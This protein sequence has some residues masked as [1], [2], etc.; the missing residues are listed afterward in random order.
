MLG[1]KLNH[2]SKR[3]HWCGWEPT[4]LWH[5]FI[6]VLDSSSHMHARGLVWFGLV[7][8]RLLMKLCNWL[9][10]FVLGH[11]TGNGIVV[12]LPRPSFCSSGPAWCMIDGSTIQWGHNQHD[13]ISNHRRLHC[14]LN[15]WFRCTS[16]KTSKLC[17]TGHCEG[18]SSVTGEFPAQKANSAD[19]FHLMTS[20]WRI[21]QEK[22]WYHIQCTGPKKL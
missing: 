16:K 22:L 12:I 8:H 4:S 6:L 7:N 17:V 5:A 3:G 19:S 1:L 2:V 11:L 20:P 15:C 21:S 18:S 13:G 9:T 10:L 14:S